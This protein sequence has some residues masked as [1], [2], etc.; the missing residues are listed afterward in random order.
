[1]PTRQDLSA[2]PV[3]ALDLAAARVEHEALGREIAE[4]D[5]RYYGQ[6]AP[7]ISDAEYD[8]LR[9]RYE[10]IETRF[11]ELA[12]SDSLSRKIGAKAA[13]KFAKVRHRVPMLSLANAFSEEEVKDF[14]ARVRRFLGL[15]DDRV[16]S[17]S[18]EPK[19]DGL[20]LS[21]RY[22]GGRLVTAARTSPLTR[23]RSRTSR[24]AS[25]A[26]TCRRSATFAVRFT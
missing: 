16:L 19:I 4:H 21:L 5:E 25:R 13:E 22:E 10:E 20:S 15:P 26:R 6:D 11:P 17:F 23:A 9:R 3:T 12:H 24:S 14:V 1:M 7:S 2:T 8:A 18:A